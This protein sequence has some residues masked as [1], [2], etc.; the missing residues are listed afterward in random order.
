VVTEVVVEAEVGGP[1][2]TPFTTGPSIFLTV[3][4][5]A[6]YVVGTSVPTTTIPGIKLVTAEV[7]PKMTAPAVVGTVATGALVTELVVQIAAI[8]GLVIAVAV[9][10]ETPWFV[11]GLPLKTMQKVVRILSNR[12]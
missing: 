12:E 1:P 11:T 2:C 9:F 6:G 10:E 4:A 8:T 5:P 7:L 3:A